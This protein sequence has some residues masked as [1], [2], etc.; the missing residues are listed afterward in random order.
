ML[1]FSISIEKVDFPY[2]CI[3]FLIQQ[4]T[5][6]LSR[7]FRKWLSRYQ[8]FLILKRDIERKRLKYETLVQLLHLITYVIT[9]NIH[10]ENNVV[11]FIGGRLNTNYTLLRLVDEHI[12]NR[13][14]T[15]N[16]RFYNVMSCTKCAQTAIHIYELRKMVAL[17]GGRTNV[18]SLTLSWR[19]ARTCFIDV[20]ATFWNWDE[21][22]IL[23]IKF[24]YVFTPGLCPKG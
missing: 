19:A 1:L 8:Q 24:F 22:F 5:E 10:F 18:S 21:R 17:A 16:S 15:T 23:T 7:H 20:G 11:L 3:N 14:L 6:F 9:K 12:S 13:E 4:M 2:L